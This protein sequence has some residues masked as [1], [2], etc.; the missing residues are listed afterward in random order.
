MLICKDV[1]EA[2]VIEYEAEIEVTEDYCLNQPT[3]EVNISLVGF[4]DDTLDI[5]VTCEQCDCGPPGFNSRVC[6]FRGNLICGG[7]QCK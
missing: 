4:K 2:Q 3:G 1:K 7:C 6:N 5:T